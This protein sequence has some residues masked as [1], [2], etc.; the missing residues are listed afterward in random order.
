MPGDQERRQALHP[1]CTAFKRWQVALPPA[2]VGNDQI[3][4]E[5]EM[6][7]TISRIPGTTDYDVWINSTRVVMTKVELIAL[8][9]IIEDA[10]RRGK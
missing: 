10:L 8:H 4:G 3:K 2:P 6:N 7:I 1:D 9:G 5:T